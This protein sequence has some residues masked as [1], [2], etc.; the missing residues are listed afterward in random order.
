MAEGILGLGTGQASTLNQDLITKLKDAERKSSIEPIETD[1]SDWELESVK[2]QEITLYAN[3]MLDAIKPFDLFITSGTNAFEDKSATTTGESVVFDAV[4]AGSLNTGTT[5]VNITSLAQRDVYQ[6][7]TFSDKTA[8]ISNTSGDKISVNG[9]EFSL[10]NKSYEDLASEINLKSD[11]N[12]SVEEVGTDSFRLVI[13]SENSGTDNA[14]EIIETGYDLGFNEFLSDTTVASGTVPASG[15]TLTLNGTSFTTDGSETYSEFISRIDADGDFEASID[16]N[17]QVSIRRED[18]TALEA[19]TDEIGLDL[20]NNNHT[21]HAQ[22]LEATIDGV[23][24]NVS[25]NAI[26]VDGGLKVTAVK[27]GISTISIEK[28][29][30]QITTLVESFVE[31]YNTLMDTIDTELYSSDSEIVDKSTLRNLVG[32]IKDFL[33]NNYGSNSDLN[34][35]NYGFSVDSNGTLSLDATTFNTAVSDD[36]DNLKDLFIGTAES[37]GLGTQLKEYVDSLDGY[38]GLLT[39]YEDNMNV[40]KTNLEEELQSS[41]DDLDNKYAQLTQQFADYGTIITRFNSQFA[42]L[43]MMIQ[44]SV[45][46]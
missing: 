37:E 20:V 9:V 16:V 25:S 24:Y 21:L 30:T 1:L 45:A 23:D 18:G 27:E 4:D 39:A 31:K 3:D 8:S 43:E 36:Y 19:T 28:D 22:N 13:K 10:L 12:A 34:L 5:T 35:F 32:Q 42:G 6:S 7:A 33:F 14:L 26:T 41:T 38:Q 29:T 17:G 11:F 2:L 40:R 44:Q 15:L 46:G